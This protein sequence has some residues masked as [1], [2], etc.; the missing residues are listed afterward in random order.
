VDEYQLFVTP[1]IVGG[2][3]PALPLGAR[4]SLHLVDQRRFAGGFV[5]LRYRAQA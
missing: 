4:A 2:G 1:V 3:L 5:F